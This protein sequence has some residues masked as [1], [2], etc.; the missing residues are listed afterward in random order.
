MTFRLKTFLKLKKHTVKRGDTILEVVI[1][2]AI[3]STVM[4]ATFNILQRAI[5]TNLNVKNRVIALNIAREGVEA[6]RNIRDT[7]WLKYSGDRRKK[8]LCLDQVSDRNACEGNPTA[9]DFINGNDETD[10]TYY[11]VDYD[12]TDS[13]FYLSRASLQ[14]EI[15]FLGSSQTPAERNGY[16][17]YLTNSVPQRYTHDST[18]ATITPFYRQIYLDIENPYDG[19]LTAGANAFCGA[20]DTDDSCRNSRLKVVSRVFWEEDPRTRRATLEAHLYDFFERDE[21]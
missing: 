15:D 10:P 20:S 2:T 4:I 14:A 17:L 12:T 21:Y 9:T 13:R 18:N 1:A 5:D 6:V 19:T 7:N 11:T 3:L 16:R 8:W